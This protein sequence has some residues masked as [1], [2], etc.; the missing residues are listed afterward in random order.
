M[1]IHSY[2]KMISNHDFCLNDID[3]WQYNNKNDQSNGKE[4]FYS[5]KVK[6][7]GS[8]SQG[9]RVSSQELEKMLYLLNFPWIYSSLSSL[10]EVNI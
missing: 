3:H 7:V 5:P 10:H 8:F 4:L 9:R 1:M 6:G 2:S